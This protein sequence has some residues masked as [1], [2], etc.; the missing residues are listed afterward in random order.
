MKTAL[1]AGA[2]LL[3]I[4]AVH[5]QP[6]PAKR[7]GGSPT[8][9]SERPQPPG[10]MAGRFAAGF[11]RL[12]NVLTDEQ[13]ASLREAMED[14]REK[15][16]DLEEKLRDARKEIF[17]SG[18]TGKFDEDAVRA[19]AMTAAKLEAEMTVLRARAFSKLN[20]PLSGEQIEKIKNAAPGLGEGREQPRRRPE[21]RRD[22]NGL[23]LRKDTPP[24][25][26]QPKPAK[27]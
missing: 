14:Q 1:I 17:E 6:E 16:R 21:T 18:L 5:A 13:R 27:P 7:P 10:P 19:K 26:T 2:V 20:P 3:S 22:E 25:A 9:R 24:E 15:V 23:P 4:L 8:D 11:E 12:F